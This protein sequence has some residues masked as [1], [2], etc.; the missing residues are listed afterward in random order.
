[1]IDLAV[2]RR[3]TK[4][5]ID[6]YPVTLT[7]VPRAKVKKPAGGWAWEEQAPRDPQVVTLIEPG[8]IPRPTLTVDGVERMVDFELLA[9]HTAQVARGDIFVHQGREWEVTEIAYD[10]GW[11]IRAL[12]TGRG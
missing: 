9:E 8:A 6:H 11:E 1:M 7:L 12:V 5:F 3:L 2:N 4:A 10:N